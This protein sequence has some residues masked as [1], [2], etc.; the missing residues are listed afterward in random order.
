MTTT[1][2][3]GAMPP[4]EEIP[5]IPQHRLLIPGEI[6]MTVRYLQTNDDPLSHPRWVGRSPEVGMRCPLCGHETWDYESWANQGELHVQMGYD[7]HFERSHIGT[8]IIWRKVDFPGERAALNSH[9][10]RRESSVIGDE[11]NEWDQ[12]L[13]KLKGDCP[14]DTVVEL[15]ADDVQASDEILVEHRPPTLEPY[16]GSIEE[17]ATLQVR[18]LPME[19]IR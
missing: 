18:K 2:T 1:T 7:R 3:K 15:V 5:E 19:K 10:F 17:G 13:R 11:E 6:G 16:P 8:K 9:P 4:T 12:Y 14:D